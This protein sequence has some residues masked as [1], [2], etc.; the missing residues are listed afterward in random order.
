MKLMHFAVSD[1]HEQFSSSICWN[2]SGT[3][4]MIFASNNITLTGR[5]GW[6]IFKYQ[7]ANFYVERNGLWTDPF[8]E[9]PWDLVL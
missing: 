1:S 9:I 7:S 5:S 8:Y 2:F 3:S 6:M 4:S